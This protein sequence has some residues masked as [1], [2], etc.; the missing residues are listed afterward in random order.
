MVR[1]SLS[2]WMRGQR[3]KIS[4]MSC[5]T[6]NSPRPNSP[7]SVR[8]SAASSSVSASLRPAAGSS[9][10]RNRGLAASAPHDSEQALL[11]A[12]Q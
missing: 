1:P 4:L 5:S 8:S 2:T 6:I 12:R 7:G 11:S 3:P 10:R 9:S